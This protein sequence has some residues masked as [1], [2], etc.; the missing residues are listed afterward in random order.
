MHNPDR[1][2]MLLAVISVS[3]MVML[4]LVGTLWTIAAWLFGSAAR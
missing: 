1:G 4:L 2:S 3:F